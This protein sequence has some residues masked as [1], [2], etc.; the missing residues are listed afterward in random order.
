MLN[1]LTQ[2]NNIRKPARTYL[3][4]LLH[5]H[6]PNRMPKITAEILE[7]NLEKII[8]EVPEI[9]AAYILDATGTQIIDNISKTKTYKIGKNINR[10]D[11][12]FFY[13]AVKEKKCI[14]TDPYPSNLNGELVVSASMPIYNDK[15]ELQYIRQS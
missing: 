6:I 9:D 5:R 2:F 8:N 15:N 3:C 7:K 12:G 14:L 13:R 10:N 1:V 11:R 4:Y